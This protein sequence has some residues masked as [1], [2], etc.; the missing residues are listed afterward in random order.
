MEKS[1]IIFTTIR[2]GA[3]EMDESDPGARCPGVHYQSTLQYYIPSTPG[4]GG[5]EGQKTL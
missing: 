1:D 5:K 4:V 3:G 2:L